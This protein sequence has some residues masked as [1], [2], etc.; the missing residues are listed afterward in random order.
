MFHLLTLPFRLAFGLLIA[1]LC[2]PFVLLGLPFLLLRVALKA[3]IA[4]IVLPFTVLAAAAGLVIASLALACAL[5]I[6]LLPFAFVAVC[7]WALVQAA[8][9]RRSPAATG[10][11]G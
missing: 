1:I 7:V 3:T 9:T 8:T 11:R 4:L 10:G 5:L 6:P 2:L